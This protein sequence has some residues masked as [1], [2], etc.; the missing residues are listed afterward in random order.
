[1]AEV[2][3]KVQVQLLQPRWSEPFATNNY[4]LYVN[5]DL[6]TERSWIWDF[7]TV[8]DEDIWVEVPTHISHII[9]LEPIIDHR[10][11]A[12]FGL[13][14]FRVNNW[15]KPDW[16]GAKTQLSFIIE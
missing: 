1:M 14:N 16:G 13:R 5:D 8:I 3:L 6:I 11:I 10:S 7:N 2:N 4:R 9:R 12:Q 15:P